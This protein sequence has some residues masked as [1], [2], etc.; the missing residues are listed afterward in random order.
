MT[1]LYL[2]HTNETAFSSLTDIYILGTQKM[3]EVQNPRLERK[4]IF[5]E[6]PV[7]VAKNSRMSRDILHLFFVASMNFSYQWTWEY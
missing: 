5:I 2:H 4:N 6:D 1:Y 7:L 3:H